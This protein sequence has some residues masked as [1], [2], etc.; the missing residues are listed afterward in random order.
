MVPSLHG[1]SFETDITRIPDR[2]NEALKAITVRLCESGRIDDV[3]FDAL[4]DAQDGLMTLKA[5][6]GDG[7]P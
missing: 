2:T 5:E 7:A 1:L 4:A 6:R 3:E